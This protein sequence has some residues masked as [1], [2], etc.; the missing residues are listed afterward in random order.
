MKYA[1]LF[2]GGKDSALALWKAQKAGLDVKY[3]VTVFPARD[4]SYMFHK[5]NLEF[6]PT[7]AD[8]LD[9][10]FIKVKTEG[11]KEEELTDLKNGL[12]KLDVGGVITG[13]VASS[14][15]F[16]RL[17]RLT[18]ELDLDLYAPLWEV[19]QQDILDTLLK[20]DF[21]VIIVSV[22]AMGFDKDWLGREID[23]GCV[24][25]LKVLNRK[26]AINVAGEGGEYESFVLDSPNYEW[27]FKVVHAE[28]EWDGHRGVYKIKKIKKKEKMDLF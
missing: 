28:R 19:K 21:K 7:L 12:N 9:L 15:Q 2:S 8:S 20:N 14:Y 4:D 3:L 16:K 26:Y 5:P 1:A 13:A 6:V 24:S 11:V 25:D 23:S 18:K 10:N 17:K 27:G 22:A